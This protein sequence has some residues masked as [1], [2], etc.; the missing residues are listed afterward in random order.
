MT[1]IINDYDMVSMP[2]KTICSI[3]IFLLMVHADD[4]VFDWKY[5]QQHQEQKQNLFDMYITVTYE[6]GKYNCVMLII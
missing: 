3:I 4:Y 2:N 1:M 5:W 6:G